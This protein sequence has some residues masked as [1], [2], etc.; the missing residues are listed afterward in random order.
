M[1]ITL[2][3]F[4]D[5]P[6]W[7]EAD[8]HLARVQSEFPD[9]TVNRRLVDTPEEAVR[10]GFRGSPS[11]LIDGAD[12]FSDSD[13]PVGLSCRIYQTPVGPAGSP[14]LHQIRAAVTSHR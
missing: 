14:T 12:P 13:A 5:C 2:L 6:N 10:L 4:D 9:V 11:I 1:E 7:T 8:D 3:Y